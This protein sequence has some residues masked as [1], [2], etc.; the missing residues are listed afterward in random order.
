MTALGLDPYGHLT[1]PPGPGLEQW[2]YPDDE[3]LDVRAFENELHYVAELHSVERVFAPALELGGH[4]DHNVIA[5]IARDVFGDGVTYYLTYTANGRSR[6]R[7]VE[8][9][10][11]WIARKYA[12]LACYGSQIRSPATQIWFTDDPIREYVP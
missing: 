11:E 5:E 3:A 4:T 8:W 12:A 9:E 6:G 10:P 2:P 7:Q 1:V